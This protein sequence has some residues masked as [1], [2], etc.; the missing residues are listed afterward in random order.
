M[1]VLP[2]SYFEPLFQAF[3]S[4]D[5]QFNNVSQNYSV[6][7]NLTQDLLNLLRLSFLSDAIMIFSLYL[8]LWVPKAATSQGSSGASLWAPLVIHLVFV[9]FPSPHSSVQVERGFHKVRGWNKVMA[10]VLKVGLVPPQEGTAEASLL[11]GAQRRGQL[12]TQWDGSHLQARR[13]QGCVSKWKP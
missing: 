2:A 8:F 5:C 10:G 12:S 1:I 13:G 3:H 4:G 6:K 7:T 11:S 9:S